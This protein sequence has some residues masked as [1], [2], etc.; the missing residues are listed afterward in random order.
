MYYRVNYASSSALRTAPLNETPAC[1]CELQRPFIHSGYWGGE[2]Y[3]RT[4]DADK[5]ERWPLA[6]WMIPTPALEGYYI[7]PGYKSV[8]ERSCARVGRRDAALGLLHRFGA[9]R[10]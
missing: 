2:R 8:G 1:C 3:F 5:E 4:T 10:T 6:G 9:Y 7:V